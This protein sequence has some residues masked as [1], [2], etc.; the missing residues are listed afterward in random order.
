MSFK[1]ENEIYSARYV[2]GQPAYAVIVE[3]KPTN[4]E[5]DRKKV[6]LKMEI[7]EKSV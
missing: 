2:T 4:F 1:W 3:A 7:W 5:N 6:I